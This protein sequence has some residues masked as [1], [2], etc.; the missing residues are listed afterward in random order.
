M[1]APQRLG[2][3]GLLVAGECIVAVEPAQADRGRANPLTCRGATLLV[4]N[5]HNPHGMAA[6]RDCLPAGGSC[7]W[8]RPATAR[9]KPSAKEVLAG[10]RARPAGALAPR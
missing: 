6:L 5:A 1:F 8:D 2:H 10:A 3:R 4:D 7:S 9:T